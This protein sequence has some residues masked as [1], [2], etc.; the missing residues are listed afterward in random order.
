MKN[1]LNSIKNNW[2]SGISV[3]MVSIP[4]SLS[5][6]IAAGA[7]PMTGIIT[8]VFAGIVGGLIGGS[9]FNIL[10]PAG[11]LTGILIGYSILYGPEILPILAILSGIII[12]IIWA[13]KWD[14]YLIFV[15]SSV[16]HGFTLGVAITIG[17]GQINSAL[18]IVGL[19]THESL[20]KNISE[21]LT[22]ID[23]LNWGAF[24]P[25]IVGLSLLF[26]ML[27]HKP[28]WPNAIIV[29]ILGII[30]GYFSSIGIIHIT[31]QTIGNKY[32][33]LN[34]NLFLFPHLSSL[35]LNTKFAV[36]ST[37][38]Q[39]KLLLSGSAV[40]A[41][42]AVLETLISAK[43]AD[44]MTKTKFNQGKEVLGVGF[45]NIASGIFGG[46]PASG[47]FA[48]TAL[49]VKSGAQSSYSQTINA[50]SVGII[51]VLFISGFK[52]LPLS[53]TAAIL[54]Y[55]SVRMVTAEH[56]IKLFRFDK[57]SFIL[58]MVVA[59]LTFAYDATTGILVGTLAALLMFANKLSKAEL[60]SSEDPENFTPEEDTEHAIIY[61]IAGTLNYF[62]SKSHLERLSAIR[63]DKPIILNFRY[64][65][66]IDTDGYEAL[67]EIVEII[68]NRNQKIYVTGV[69]PER[70]AELN[71]HSWFLRMEKE[72][73]I[74]VTNDKAI[75]QI[76][77]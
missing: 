20:V 59:F 58:S 36:L 26:T 15:P 34:N 32:P 57:Y 61:R 50:V 11:A 53:I 43:T 27:K 13:L 18:G 2:K 46:L 54:V 47:V 5:L 70:K 45:A 62:N 73:K 17:L 33:D 42:V 38:E 51:S 23:S 40:I 4:L 37:T 22:H 71:E 7:S 14:R 48:R 75:E 49:N 6:A 66:Y 25:F 21:S 65:H 16:I 19:P 72:N 9:N 44:G 67:D 52:Y 8:A 29:A 28:N 60:N 63:K 56:F 41:F 10:G 55:A 74:F 77:K 1:I 35:Y 68:E 12:I 3:A 30:F 76:N 24:I 39:I 69:K 64:L 31:F